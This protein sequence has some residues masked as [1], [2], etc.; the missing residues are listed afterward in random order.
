MQKNL[1]RLT[2]SA[3]TDNYDMIAALLAIKM[4]YGWQEDSGEDKYQFIVHC[5]EKAFLEDLARE[6]G[7][8]FPQA[9]LEY[10]EEEKRDWLSSWKEFFTPVLCGEKYVILPPWRSAEEFDDR[11]K[12]IIDPKSAFGTGHHASTVLCLRA[13]DRLLNS[14]RLLPGQSFLDLGCGTGVLGIGAALAGLEGVCVDI[15]PLALENARDNAS[16]NKVE[17]LLKLL[18]GSVEL[19]QGQ[20]FDLIMA[21]I[22]AGPLVDMAPEIRNCLSAQGCLI[23]SGILQSQADAVRQAYEKCSLPRS[24]QLVDGEWCALVWA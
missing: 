24:E 1:F 23:L 2:I 14:R 12:I 8:K 21:N 7:E 17:R 15:D 11:Y 3:P 20:K 4:P 19:L 6:L 5:E 16:L 9:G 10:A 18:E 22:L 13:L